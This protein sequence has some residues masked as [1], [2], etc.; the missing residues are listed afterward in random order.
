M[1]IR[2]GNGDV[3]GVGSAGDCGLRG[4]DTIA[5]VMLIVLSILVWSMQPIAAAIMMT[6]LVILMV[7]MMKGW[8]YGDDD[9]DDNGYDHGDNGGGRSECDNWWGS[10]DHNYGWW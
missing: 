4:S 9:G 5:A 3:F 10:H 8:V 7:G 6:I 2:C 1:L